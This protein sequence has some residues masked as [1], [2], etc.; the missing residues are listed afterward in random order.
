MKINLSNKINNLDLCVDEL[1]KYYKDKGL[2]IVGLNDSLG[3]NVNSSFLKKDLLDNLS[4]LLSTKNFKPKVINAFSLLINKTEHIDYLLKA[5]LSVEEIKLAQLYSAISAFSQVARDI[6]MPS[7]VGQI[8]NLYKL[9]YKVRENDK[10]VFITTELQNNIEPTVIYS[11]GANNLM[12]EVDSDPYSIKKQYKLKEIFPKYYYTL[13]R[14]QDKNTLTKVLDGV[15]RNFDNILS[16]NDKTDIYALGVYIPKSL[17]KD[18]MMIFRDLIYKY[19]ESLKEICN[20][21]KINYI[22]TD[23][24]I[25]DHLNKINDFHI[26]SD[27]HKTL[28]N[29]ILLRMYQQKI[30]FSSVKREL[31]N[32]NFV[33]DNRRSEGIVEQLEKDEFEARLKS[34]RMG[35]FDKTHQIKIEKEHKMEKEVFNKV[36]RKIKES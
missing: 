13:D 32:N 2:L 15:K 34:F 28:A 10:N 5:N 11:S 36:L 3:L 30:L 19:N 14:A 31:V 22:D 20:L 16:I 26:D 35:G 27:G 18:D 17:N 1:A 25:S 12:R 21:Y 4:A 23:K 8:A 29:Y 24:V 7:N 9:V 6:K 33:I